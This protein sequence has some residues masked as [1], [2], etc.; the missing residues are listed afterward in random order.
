M[1][2]ELDPANRFLIK[3]WARPDLS[4]RQSGLIVC[5]LNAPNELLD[6]AFSG[7]FGPAP[8]AGT[9]RNLTVPRRK[10][11]AVAHIEM[12]CYYA[13]RLAMRGCTKGTRQ[14]INDQLEELWAFEKLV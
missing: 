10:R 7:R 3:H 12:N 8:V 11:N 6:E 4:L 13:N 14:M 9:T 2:A 5:M 1:G